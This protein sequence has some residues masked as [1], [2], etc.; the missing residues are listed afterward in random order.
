MKA[1]THLLV[2]SLYSSSSFDDLQRPQ[3]EIDGKSCAAVG[4][5]S[6][7]A[8]YDTLFNQVLT[9]FL[10]DYMPFNLI[11]RIFISTLVLVMYIHR[12]FKWMPFSVINF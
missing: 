6:L 2:D 7:M 5:N 1:F 3:G 4:Q 8:L 10:Q 11:T 12:L 9:V